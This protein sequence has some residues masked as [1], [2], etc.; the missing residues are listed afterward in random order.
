MAMGQASQFAPD[1]SK[2]K[3]SLGRIFTLLD[4]EPSID[5]YAQTGISPVSCS[6]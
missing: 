5:I 6:K 1:Y 4:S 3:I 2:V